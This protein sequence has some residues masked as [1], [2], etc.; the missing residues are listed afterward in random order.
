MVKFRVKEM[1]DFLMV[2]EGRGVR[3]DGFVERVGFFKVRCL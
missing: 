2:G 3:K 1:K